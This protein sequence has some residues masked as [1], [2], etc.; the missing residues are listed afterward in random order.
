MSSLGNLDIIMLLGP[1]D[2]VVGLQSQQPELALGK[3]SPVEIII[4]QLLDQGGDSLLK[5]LVFVGRFLL[6]KTGLG[7]NQQ[8]QPHRAAG[9][10]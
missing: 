8:E 1:V 3:F 6:G 5:R 2:R 7:K 4:P 9:K 10:K